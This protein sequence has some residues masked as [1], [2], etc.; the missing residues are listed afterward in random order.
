MK[1]TL[2]KQELHDVLHFHLVV[3]RL[4]C[5]GVQDAVRDVDIASDNVRELFAEGHDT[6][7]SKLSQTGVRVYQ[8]QE[9]YLV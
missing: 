8:F 6:A 5:M 7:S 2:T 9:E 3:M 1:L 4:A